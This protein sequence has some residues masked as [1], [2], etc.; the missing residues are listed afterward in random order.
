MVSGSGVFPFPDT[1]GMGM[2]VDMVLGGESASE[3]HFQQILSPGL[4][5]QISSTLS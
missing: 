1:K 3:P 2:G 4:C 5:L